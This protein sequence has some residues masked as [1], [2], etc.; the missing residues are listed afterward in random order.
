MNIKQNTNMWI[1]Y[2]KGI[3]TAHETLRQ[4]CLIP[5]EGIGKVLCSREDVCS[6]QKKKY[7]S[8][9]IW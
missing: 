9:L 6:E 3:N 1:R 7:E 5:P 4:K 8:Y 2:N